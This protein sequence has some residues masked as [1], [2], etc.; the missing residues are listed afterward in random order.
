MVFVHKCSEVMMIFFFDFKTQWI[1]SV[2]ILEPC[3]CKQLSLNEY[4]I[5]N[6]FGT[7]HAGWLSCTSGFCH[8]VGVFC[9]TMKAP[10][11]HKH[12]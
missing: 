12:F 7:C 10:L 6:I 11:E 4:D 1:K 8:G 9:S 3:S 2:G 5:L